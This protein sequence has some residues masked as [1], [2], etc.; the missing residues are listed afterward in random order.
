MNQID[1]TL[2]C[3]IVVIKLHLYSYQTWL[4]VWYRFGLW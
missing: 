1:P 3:C 2:Y 4:W